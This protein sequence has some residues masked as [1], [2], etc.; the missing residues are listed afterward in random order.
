MAGEGI[1]AE[2]Q[3]LGSSI[4]A[5]IGARIRLRREVL[6][7]GVGTTAQSVGISKDKMTDVEHGRCRLTPSQMALL[8]TR[9]DVAVTWFFEDLAEEPTAPPRTEPSAR[10]NVVPF[11]S[12]TAS[13]SSVS[14]IPSTKSE[15]F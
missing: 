10:D 4:E 6:H 1:D 15:T 8:A 12:S 2:Q 5:Q 9:L 11:P 14:A 13:S 3:A 7:L